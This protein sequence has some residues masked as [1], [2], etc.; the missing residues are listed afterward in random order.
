MNQYETARDGMERMLSI[1]ETRM[2]AFGRKTYHKAFTDVY[3][4]YVPVFDAIEELYNSV[5]EPETLLDQMAHVLS[6]SGKARVDQEVKKA[7]KG[8]AEM[9][10]NLG[11][12]VYIYPSILKYAGNSSQPLVDAIGKAWKEAFPKSNVQPAELEY[13]ENGFHHK[14]CY[15]TTA[16][17]RE[18][19]RSDD[20]YELS[21]L[22]EYRDGYM[23]SLPEGEELIEAYY[24]MA[25]TIVKHIDRSGH[26]D[27]IYHEVWEEYLAPCIGLIEEGRMEECRSL[28]TQM[29]CDLREQYFIV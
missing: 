3:S 17:C 11:L 12:C 25:P 20:C 4:Q 5:K 14:W 13:I 22:R 18:T 10:L 7:G 8:T 26:A 6:D 15:I 16:V 21:V 2:N 29:V 24:D 23:R 19:G 28:Y 9:N 27:Q 1:A